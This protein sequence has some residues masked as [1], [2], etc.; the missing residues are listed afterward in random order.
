MVFQ[1]KNE[2]VRSRKPSQTVLKWKLRRKSLDVG[3]G[4]VSVK[5]QSLFLST[6]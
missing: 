5:R 2:E 6:P 3:T 4:N 1:F